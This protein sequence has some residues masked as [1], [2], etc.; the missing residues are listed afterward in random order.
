MSSYIYMKILESQPDRYDRGIAWLSF[1]QADKA[2]KKIVD[3]NVK[4]GMKIL[5]IGSG[6]GTLAVLAA[7]KGARVTGFDVSPGMLEVARNKVEAEGLAD[8]VELHEMGVAGMDKLED[9]SFD[10][11]VSTLVFSELSNDEQAYALKNAYR[12]LKPEGRLAIA[13]EAKPERLLNKILHQAVR[14]PLLIVTFVLTQ[15]STSAVSGLEDLVARAGF[16]IE[17]VER[18]ALE[19]FLY[20]I[21]IKG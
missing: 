2:K 18:S 6:T 7:K 15:T 8:K 10:L 19:S 14:V 9:E 11:V 5:E 4:E 17:K 20:L 13:D 1:G 3:E 21:A 12:I 16:K